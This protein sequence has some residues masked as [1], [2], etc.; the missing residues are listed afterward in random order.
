M[1]VTI[2]QCKT[3]LYCIVVM[4]ERPLI[5]DKSFSFYPRALGIGKRVGI[6]LKE[7]ILDLLHDRVQFIYVE[8][9][10]MK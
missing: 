5:L 3:Q 4:T 8:D 2:E 10:P 9:I 1:M 7:S 6:S